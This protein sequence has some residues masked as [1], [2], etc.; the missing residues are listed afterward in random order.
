[1]LYKRIID[2]PFPTP[3]SVICSPNHIKKAEP[4]VNDTMM[5]ETDVN[6]ILSSVRY[7]LLPNPIAIA[8]LSNTE[9]PIVTYLVYSV[10]FFLPSSPSLCNSSKRGIAIVRS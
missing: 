10:S 3:F 4:A 6:V 1:M 8:A 5:T 7:P 9:S 2:I